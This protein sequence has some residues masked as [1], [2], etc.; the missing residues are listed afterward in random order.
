MPQRP[1][2]SGVRRHRVFLPILLAPLLM[3]GCG[4]G[5]GSSDPP[6]GPDLRGEWV[7]VFLGNGPR[8]ALTATILQDGDAIMIRTSLTG[9]GANLSGTSSTDGSLSLTDAFDGEIW[10][11]FSS[12]ASATRVQI[13]DFLRSPAPDDPN[14]PL[15]TIELTRAI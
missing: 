7:G 3:S 11:T 14:A 6:V 1:Y 10:S 2:S 9:I 13:Q 5:G 15:Q 12:K 4:G 8:Q